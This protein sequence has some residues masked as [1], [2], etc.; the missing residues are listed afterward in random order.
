MAFSIDQVRAT[1]DRVLLR[2]LDTVQDETAG[3]VII[4]DSAQEAGDSAEVVAVGPGKRVEGSSEREDMVLSIG[5]KVLIN[6]F[7]GTELTCGSETF[8]MVREQDVLAIVE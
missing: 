8:V 6:K 5:N 3:G 1:D 4:P 7:A 2:K